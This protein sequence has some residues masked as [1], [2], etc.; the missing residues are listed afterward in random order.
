M[1][2][3]KSCWCYSSSRQHVEF[4]ADWNSACATIWLCSNWDCLPV[5]W[6]W[7]KCGLLTFHSIEHICWGFWGFVQAPGCNA[8]RAF[9][10]L[11]HLC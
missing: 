5:V 7:W 10:K 4:G 3:W 11:D 2:S 8:V 6:L 1:G 9:D